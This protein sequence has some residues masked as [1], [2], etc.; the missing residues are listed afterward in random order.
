[1]CQLHVTSSMHL[2]LKEES[3]YKS[4]ERHVV[5]HFLIENSKGPDIQIQ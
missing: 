5:S 1:M 3:N 4:E 2:T